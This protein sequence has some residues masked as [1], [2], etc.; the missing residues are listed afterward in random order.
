[1][2]NQLEDFL[3]FIIVEKGLAENTIVCHRRDLKKYILYLT[4]VEQ[5]TSFNVVT[6]IIILNYLYFLKENGSS[7]ST[8]A[9]T[10][11]SIRS[12]HQFLLREK[13]LRRIQPYILKHQSKNEGYQKYYPH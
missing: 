9:R 12:F 5:I 11:A 13:W 7:R 4:N 2:N 8:M 10:I 3:H 1:M 6:R